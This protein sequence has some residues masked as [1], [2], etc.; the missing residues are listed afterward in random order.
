MKNWKQPKYLSVGN[1]KLIMVN[2]ALN[3]SAFNR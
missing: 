2:H 3:L 1:I